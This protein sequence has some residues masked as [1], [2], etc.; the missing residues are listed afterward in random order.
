[1]GDATVLAVAGDLTAQD[2][3]VVVNAANSRLAHGGGVAAALARAGG[4]AVQQASDDWVAAHGE[5][6]PGQAAVTTA[7]ALPARAIVH[8][9]G[10]VHRSGQDNAGLLRGAVVAAL[11]AAREQ[12]ARSVALP[13]ISAG[14]YGYPPE[15]AAVVIAE[16]AV[17]WLRDGPVGSVAEVRLVG[18]DT[19][20]A[21]RFADALP[22]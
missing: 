3:D 17:S 12:G 8:V 2:V 15:D 7:G 6:G 1:V 19:A 9:V 11:D 21:Q 13:A 16:A 18:F 20:A 22:E 4:P 14:I 10:P 5:V